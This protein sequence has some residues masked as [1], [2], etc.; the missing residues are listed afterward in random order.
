WMKM[1]RLWDS[2]I[3][4]APPLPI[5]MYVYDTIEPTLCPCGPCRRA[6]D[7]RHRLDRDTAA[8]ACAEEGFRDGGDRVDCSGWG[9]IGAGPGVGR[10]RRR[11]E[12]S[13][14]PAVRSSS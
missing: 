12:R 10:G 5:N 6:R 11:R 7:V 13:G 1:F 14:Q 9:Q 8:P 4:Q 3:I 2:V